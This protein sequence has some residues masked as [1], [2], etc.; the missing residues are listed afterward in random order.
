MAEEQRQ[1]EANK[2]NSSYRKI[3]D[4]IQKMSSLPESGQGQNS[5][6]TSKPY[7]S[8]AANQMASSFYGQVGDLSHRGGITAD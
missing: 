2:K 3:L 5:S 6:S 7:K 1:Y 4:G 8:S